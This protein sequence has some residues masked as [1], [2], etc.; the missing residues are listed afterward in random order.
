MRKFLFL[1]IFLTLNDLAISQDTTSNN[2][3]EDPK[4]SKEVTPLEVRDYRGR[5]LRLVP[6][7]ED[8]E[9][10]Q[11][12]RTE[13]PKLCTETI[14]EEVNYLNR[15]DGINSSKLRKNAAGELCSRP[16]AKAKSTWDDFCNASTEG[17]TSVINQANEFKG[18]TERCFLTGK[19]KSKAVTTYEQSFGLKL[20]NDKTVTLWRKVR[21]TKYIPSASKGV[22]PSVPHRLPTNA[23]LVE[24]TFKM[25][26]GSCQKQ[27]TI[28]RQAG[29]AEPLFL[30]N[31]RACEAVRS[32]D[33]Q[34]WVRPQ[35][36][37]EKEAKVIKGLIVEQLKKEKDPRSPVWFQAT[38]PKSGSWDRELKAFELNQNGIR[39]CS[40]ETCVSLDE[41]DVDFSPVA[42]K[43]IREVCSSVNTSSSFSKDSGTI[44]KAPG[45]RG[46]EGVR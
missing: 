10:C 8:S 28:V 22:L 36:D 19:G 4:N 24:T 23:E 13:I 18:T 40:A 46:I 17:L 42:V 16:T 38:V 45:S 33:L 39:D 12:L 25:E 6:I 32:F 31:S 11:K 1:I 27:S 7:D 43:E 34:K 2:D 5:I 21:D 30:F 44:H 20:N 15:L 41:M 35:M 37:A 3:E 9:P 29:R 26:S 14:L